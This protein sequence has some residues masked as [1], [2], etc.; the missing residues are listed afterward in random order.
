[1]RFYASLNTVAANTTQP[2]RDLIV[3]APDTASFTCSASGL[4]RPNITWLNPSLTTVV[5][6]VSGS[7]ITEIDQ[8][9]RERVSV[10]NIAGTAPSVA[11]EYRCL[12]DNGVMGVGDIDS[13][14]ATLG[15]YGQHAYPTQS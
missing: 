15:V 11:G 13:T 7:L 5:S 10:L 1:M 12:A 8:G 2:P 6:G 4:P 3:T 14:T 9:V